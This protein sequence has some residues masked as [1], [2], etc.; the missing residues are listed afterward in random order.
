MRKLLFVAAWAAV[1]VGCQSKTEETTAESTPAPTTVP[2]ETTYASVQP[3]FAKCQ[4]C[5]GENGKDGV[6]MRTYESIM[7]GG[8]HGPIVVAG[9]PANS[10]IVQA[11]RGSHGKKQM[12]FKKAALPEAEIQ[13]VEAW[14]KYGAK[15]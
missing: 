15:A 6:D 12:P 4:P 8:E 3:I 5:H 13:A 7:K 10:V 9:D 11:L 14:I 1:I 2:A